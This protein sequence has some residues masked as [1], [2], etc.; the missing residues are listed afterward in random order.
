M[1]VLTKYIIE[2]E[3]EVEVE[4]EVGVRL[5]IVGVFQPRG[6]KGSSTPEVGD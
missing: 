4:V 2:S 3:S 5:V 1:T 6:R